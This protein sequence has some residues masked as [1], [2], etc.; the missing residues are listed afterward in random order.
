MVGGV[1]RLLLSVG[2]EGRLDRWQS[3]SPKHKCTTLD[4]LAQRMLSA[5]LR[6]VVFSGTV[7]PPLQCYQRVY[8]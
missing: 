2:T 4:L 7:S 3:A 1:E 8:A 6:E 5:T